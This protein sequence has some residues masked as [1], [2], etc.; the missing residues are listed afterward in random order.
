MK[1]T[2]ATIIKNSELNDGIWDMIVYDE[3]LT[4]DILPGQ[5]VNL[6][7]DDKSLLLPRPI[8]ICEVDKDRKT[9]RLVYKVIGK[10]TENFSSLKKGDK[11]EYIGPLG[12]GFE[13]FDNQEYDSYENNEK[14]ILIV[15]GGAGIPPL[16]ELSKRLKG[17]KKVF[18]GTEA[19]GLLEKDFEKY[20]DEVKLSSMS[21]KVGY[22]GTVIDLIIKED[23]S[24][25]IIYSCGPKP[26]LKAVVDLAN[27]KKVPAQVSVEERMAC[28]IGACLVCVCKKKE[29]E[30][31]WTY[32]R[33]CKD[34]PV[35]S[36]EEVV[37]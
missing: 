28:G 30:N 27:E 33:V 15:G 18:I 10:G 23:P 12:N 21:G 11:I 34:G 24:I 13:M 16:L 26:M 17:N 22:K 25:D 3:E 19:E 29:N 6:Y 2:K 36:K 1:K 5:F 37:L 9:L 32:S 4:E 14:N 35:Y 20:S 8:S 7:C 31:D